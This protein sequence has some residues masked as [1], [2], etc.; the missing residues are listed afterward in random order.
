[1]C[2]NGQVKYIKEIQ[3]NNKILSLINRLYSKNLTKIADKLKKIALKNDELHFKDGTI[4][5]TFD[6]QHGFKDLH[7]EDGPAVI[8]KKENGEP[9][10]T[11][12]YLDG[13]RLDRFDPIQLERYTL[14]SGEDVVN[15]LLSPDSFLRESATYYL[16]NKLNA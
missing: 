13:V 3:V 15:C 16:K 2:I 14:L 12:W 11:Y 5:N 8:L 6:G 1:M 7:R 9:I 10:K 4:S